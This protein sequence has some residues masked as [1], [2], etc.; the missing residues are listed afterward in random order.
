MVASP[1]H[2]KVLRL[3]LGEQLCLEV[4]QSCEII[5]QKPYSAL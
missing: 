1:C 4:Y 5:K 3:Y 2:V